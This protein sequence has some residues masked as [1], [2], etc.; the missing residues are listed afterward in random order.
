ML[1]YLE[2]LVEAV[3]SL[4][5]EHLPT[6]VVVVTTWQSHHSHLLNQRVRAYDVVPFVRILLHHRLAPCRLA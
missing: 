5:Y 4:L 1:T 3:G 6:T 2:Q